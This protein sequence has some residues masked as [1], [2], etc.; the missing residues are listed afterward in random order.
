M[1]QTDSP[2]GDVPHPETG[3]PLDLDTA[4]FVSLTGNQLTIYLPEEMIWYK[5]PDGERRAKEIGGSSVNF[6]AG[7]YP[8][9]D[10][11]SLSYA[12][13]KLLTEH[14]HYGDLFKLAAT[15][16]DVQETG[17]IPA[18]ETVSEP[19]LAEGEVMVNGQVMTEEEAIEMLSGSGM[20]EQQVAG[21]IDDVPSDAS[22]QELEVLTEPTNRTE[23]LEVLAER[24]VDLSGA[25]G[26][27]ATT[28]EIQ[29]FARE[30]GYII[31]KYAE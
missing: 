26:A 3:E 21:Q 15:E 27:D 24:G 4:R 23:A 31:E 22:G 7:L 9:G 2:F 12:E 17:G 5:G 10:G 14:D 19:N 11:Q 16:R 29:D 28:E 20:T 1:A 25:P 30:N 18:D 8:I 13:A 6:D